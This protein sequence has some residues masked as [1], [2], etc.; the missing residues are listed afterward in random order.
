M[1]TIKKMKDHH[2]PERP[3]KRPKR[4]L[5]IV[6]MMKMMKMIQGAIMVDSGRNGVDSGAGYLWKG[7]ESGFFYFFAFTFLYF[8]FL[9]FAFFSSFLFLHILVCMFMIAC[10]FFC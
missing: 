8:P 10:L 6:N 7:L 1:M 3:P 2:M 4:I 9:S 5:V